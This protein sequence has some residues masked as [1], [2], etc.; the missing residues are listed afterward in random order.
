MISGQEG[1]IYYQEE[2]AVEGGFEVKRQTLMAANEEGSVRFF[3]HFIHC[4]V[5]AALFML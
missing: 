5:C 2:R 1:M 3:C 4:A